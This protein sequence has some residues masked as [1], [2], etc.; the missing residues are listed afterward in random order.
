MFVSCKKKNDTLSAE[1][2]RKILSRYFAAATTGVVSSKEEMTYVLHSP[3]GKEIDASILQ[4]AIYTQPKISGTVTLT[5]QTVLKFIPEESFKN[6]SSYQMVLDLA[7]IDPERFKNKISYAFK[8]VEQEIT[9]EKQGIFIHDDGTYSVQCIVRSSDFVDKDNIKKCLQVDPSLVTISDYGKNA[10]LADIKYKSKELLPATIQYDA[11]EIGGNSNGTITVGSHDFSKLVVVDHYHELERNQLHI[12]LSQT[13]DR[14]QDMAGLITVK[15]TDA[16]FTV[17]NNKI[18]I[19]LSDIE[20]ESNANVKLSAAIKS[21]KNLSLEKDHIITVSLG[22]MKPDVQF[23]NDGNYFPA[24]G[25][26]KIPIKTRMLDAIRVVVIEI[27]Q[28]NVV[29]YLAWNSI[30]Q[31]DIYTLRMYGRPIYDEIVSLAQG[32]RDKEGWTIYGIDLENH[33]QRNPGSIYY[34]SLDYGPEQVQLAC[35]DKLKQYSIKSRIP[36]ASFFEMKDAYYDDYYY[37]G[38]PEYDWS[39]RENPCM[40][41]YY[42][43][44]ELSQRLFIC[45]NYGIIAKKGDR[46]CRVA[47]QNLNSLSPISGGQVILYNLQGIEITQKKTDNEGQVLFDNL[48]SDPQVIKVNHSGHITYMGL[49]ENQ[50]NSL[51]E[52]E[53]SSERSNEDNAFFIY[54]E[55][56]VW[57]PGDSIFLD[58]MINEN[59]ANIPENLPISLTFYNTENVVVDRKIQAYKKGTQIYNFGLCTAPSSL[60]GRY[61]AFFKIGPNTI[62]KSVRIETVKPN[63]T[64]TIFSVKEAEKDIIYSD[65]ISGVLTTKYLTGLNVAGATLLSRARVKPI[66]KPFNDFGKYSFAVSDYWENTNIDIASGKTD[67]NGQL[68]FAGGESLKK[69]GTALAI[70]LETETTLPDGGTAKEGKKFKVFPFNTFIGNA[71]QLGKGWNGNHT[72]A[73]DISIDLVSVNARGK[74][75]TSKTSINYVIQK[76]N[77]SWW[78]DKY[79]LRSEG[80]FRNAEFW[81]DV[82]N[83]TLSIYGAGKFTLPKGSLTKGAYKIIFTDEASGHRSDVLFTV[84]DGVEYIADGKPD[85]VDILTDKEEY[86][87]GESLQ[88]KIPYISGA[89]VLLSIERGNKIIDWVWHTISQQGD[90]SIPIKA[91]YAPGAYIHATIMQAY[92]QNANDLPTR[93][94]GV[95]YITIN[96][97]VVKLTPVSDMPTQIESNRDYTFSVSEAS[98]KAM[99]YTYALVDEGLLNLTGYDT[100]APSTHFNGKYSLLVK[101]WDIYKNLIAFFKGR[102]A[103]I[104]SIGGDDAY[105]PDAIPEN[106]RFKPLVI[107]KGTSYLKANSKNKHT[108]KIPNYIGKARLMV[109]ACQASAFGQ[110][111]K[112]VTVRNPIMIQSQMPRSLNVTD[113]ISIPI[114]VIRDDASIKS[115][116][117][118]II[119]PKERM[120]FEQPQGIQ[121][122][123]QDQQL[124]SVNLKVLNKVGPLQF[125]ITGSGNGKQ[126]TETTEIMVHY[127]NSYQNESSTIVLKPGSNHVLTVKPKGYKEAFLSSLIVSG[128]KVPNFD[129]YINDLIDYPYGCLEQTTSKIFGQLYMDKIVSLDANQK[130]ERSKNIDAGFENLSK[131][132]KSD[133]RFMYWDNGYYQSWA[134]I[135]AGNLLM[136]A[137]ELAQLPNRHEEMLQVWLNSQEKMANQWSISSGMTSYVYDS[138]S[139]VQAYR[140]YILAKA[141]RSARSA[142]NKYAASNKTKDPIAWWLIAGAYNYSGFDSKAVEFVNKAESLQKVSSSY[143]A[144]FGSEGRDLAIV[145]DILSTLPNQRKR[146]QQYYDRMVQVFN[147]SRWVSTQ[148]MAY[149]FIAAY[150]YFGKSL[151]ASKDISYAIQG[152]K[153]NISATH[154]SLESRRHVI[155]AGDYE[156]K[157]TIKNTGVNDLYITQNN[158]FISDQLLEPAISSN[159]KLDTKYATVSGGD[160]LSCGLGD[161]IFITLTV[162]NVTALPMDHLALNLKMPAGWDLVNPRLY[163]TGDLATNVTYQ[164]YR[165]D[166]VYTYFRLKAG[167]SKNLNFRAKAAFKGDFFMPSVVCEDMYDGKVFARSNSARVKVGQ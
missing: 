110:L 85:I 141:G 79:R 32:I 5:N 41:A 151:S 163:E 1:E 120:S 153:S 6:G 44:R 105:H 140:L 100:P 21:T 54:G 158:R 121:F 64:E 136:E 62:G 101:T 130:V 80:E 138:E 147:E 24:D 57:R 25:D 116:S 164:D 155:R 126:M 112:I 91:S 9:L 77:K 8:V 133:G 27:K 75:N 96:D 36:D 114:N 51:T 139:L 65:F 63:T 98:G 167:E 11:R 74:K 22:A 119:G 2:D 132:F 150:K 157:L 43:Y 40:P 161:D 48:D 71:R 20:S 129:R 162:T 76:H 45:S 84:Y 12:Y 14:S 47:V 34:V 104:I 134:D 159:L 125:K 26:M 107:H 7:K 61:Y 13:I 29:H 67:A 55:R 115:A 122:N 86:K 17:N 30:S 145:V 70:S 94:Y 39:N 146:S 88:L 3:L 53:I 16:K 15:D 103:G 131:F 123:G 165:D 135:Y 49:E 46:Q 144:S 68:D 143:H 124:K 95:K 37:D 87:T 19:Y 18:T 118:Q 83:G 78:V 166:R 127:P 38:G 23:L 102:Y 89:R 99:Q 113:N 106:S 69:F 149:S 97:D 90:I 156:R 50:S 92:Q 10:F 128:A 4:K 137:S 60:T 108:L 160:G 73:E 59:Q 56:E 35:K 109:I 81:S 142:L 152:L 117:I 42:L 82:K 66:E 58:L 148:E 154:K 111:E 72:Y 31:E 93:I 52:F 33:I 28:E